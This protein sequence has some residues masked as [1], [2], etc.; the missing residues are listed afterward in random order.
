MCAQRSASANFISWFTSYT[1]AR[2][3]G[4]QLYVPTITIPRRSHLPAPRTAA[5]SPTL[6]RLSNRSSRRARTPLPNAVTHRQLMHSRLSGRA[7]AAL[8]W[9]ERLR[10]DAVLLIEVGR[11]RW[12]RAR[13]ATH[14]VNASDQQP[15]SHH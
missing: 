11:V 7:F 12:V 5:H 2:N 8:R 9:N 14:A 15:G 10:A 3:G 6:R 4:D 1:H 13:V